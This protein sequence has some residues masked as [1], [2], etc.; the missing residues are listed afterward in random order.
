MVKRSNSS[1]KRLGAADPRGLCNRKGGLPE[2]LDLEYYYIVNTHV[3]RHSV[4]VGGEAKDH[5]PSVVSARTEMP[6]REAFRKLGS[7]GY[8]T[9]NAFETRT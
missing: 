6:E 4:Y 9:L 3:C 7:T 1:L 2:A 8:F 5:Y